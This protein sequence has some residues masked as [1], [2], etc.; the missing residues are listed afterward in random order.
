MKIM[1]KILFLGASFAL[2]VTSLIMPAVANAGAIVAQTRGNVSTMKDMI[3]NLRADM[4]QAATKRSSSTA[5]TDLANAIVT[6]FQVLKNN[7]KQLVPGL[8][9][10]T[11]SQQEDFVQAVALDVASGKATVAEVQ[12]LLERI[13]RLVHSIPS[14]QGI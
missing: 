1:K 13:S 7:L 8:S 12:D 5:F 11:L 2:N 4:Q 14:L 6:Q 3:K 10:V 9:D